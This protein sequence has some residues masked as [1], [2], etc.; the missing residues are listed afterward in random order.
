MKKIF[1]IESM[2]FIVLLLS[3]VS[4]KKDFL[5]L[6]PESSLV[7]GTLTTSQDAENILTGAYSRMSA[8]G[9]FQYNRFYITEGINDNHYVNGDNPQEW[10]LENF[11][12]DA[13]NGVIQDCYKDLWA[14]VGAANAV[15]TD[16]PLINDP[17]WA[18]TNRKEQILGEAAF[19]RALNYY[20]LV[21]QYGGVP[22]ITDFAQSGNYYPARNTEQEV[23]AQILKIWLLPRLRCLQNHTIV[24][25]DEQQKAQHKPF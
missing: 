8:N 19:I 7:S 22:I 6:K 11:R 12:F 15:L 24:K 13:S 16:V 5:E 21:T 2:L 23:Y 18:G 17:K 20:E 9:Y 4:C 1:K 3:A 25:M 14:Q 10:L